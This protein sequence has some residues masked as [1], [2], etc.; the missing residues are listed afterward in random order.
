MAAGIQRD[1]LPPT[2]EG[3]LMLV[4]RI[5]KE[6]T[7]RA[8]LVVDFL[9]WLDPGEGISATGS[10]TLAP[11]TGAW[12]QDNPASDPTAMPADTTPLTVHSAVTMDATTKLVLL[13]DA[14]TPGLVYLGSVLAT[15]GTSGR[16]KTIDFSVAVHT[17]EQP[18]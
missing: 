4:G 8:R 16:I 1:F 11:D 14:G 5:S 17:A 13:L 9:D 6:T 7:D 10:V 3:A 18:P 12:Q 15:G 2:G